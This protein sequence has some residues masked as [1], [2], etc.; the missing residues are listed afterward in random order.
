[1]LIAL[2]H[3]LLSGL[4]LPLHDLLSEEITSAALSQQVGPQRPGHANSFTQ[5]AMLLMA[6]SQSCLLCCTPLWQ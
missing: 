1:M 5:Q 3:C 4:S 2:L 6:C